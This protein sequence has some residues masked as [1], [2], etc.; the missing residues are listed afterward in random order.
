MPP[1]PPAAPVR[2]SVESEIAFYEEELKALDPGDKRRAALLHLE[3]ARLLEASG[4]VPSKIEA[5]VK[6]AAEVC[7]DLGTAHRT[8]RRFLRRRKA[9][10]EAV[11]SIDRELGGAAEPEARAA[12]H[13]ERGRLRRDALKLPT[14]AEDFVQAQA[15]QPADPSPA[16]ALRTLYGAQDA[17]SE[18][19]EALERAAAAAEPERGLM[20]RREAALL[21]DQALD[22]PDRAVVLW[23]LV[24]AAAPTDALAMAAVERLYAR[25]GRWLDLCGALVRFAEASTDTGAKYFAWLRA[26]MMAA[27]RLGE[28]DRAA[29]WLEEAARV[30]PHDPAPLDVLAEIHRRKG[31][32]EAWQ[33]ALARRARLAATPAERSGLAV[34][35]AQ[36]LAD[37]LGRRPEAIAV[38]RAAQAE[39]PSNPAVVHALLGLLGGEGQ[40][41]ER[42]KL[43]LL[44]A[45]RLGD[46]AARAAAMVRAGEACDRDPA[47]A[48]LARSAYERALQAAPDHRGAFEGLQRLYEQTAAWKP[49]AGLLEQ[50]IEATGDA[51]ERRALLR[52]LGM[53]RDERLQDRD[54]AIEAFEKLRALDPRDGAVLRELERLYAAAG[55]WAEHAAR[56]RAEAE[57]VEDPGTKA[58]LLWRA[59]VTAEE[60]AGDETGAK[61]AYQ[62]AVAAQPGHHAALDG[63]ARL[64]ERAGRWTESLEFADRALPGLAPAEQ[65]ARLLATARTSEE[66]LRNEAD[67][68]VRCRKALAL[69]PRH[70]AVLETL[71]RLYE[72]RG[73]WK[74]LVQVGLELAAGE[75]DPERGAALHVRNGDLLAERLESPVDAVAEYKAALA[76]VPTHEPA[77]LGLERVLARTGD[78]A[79]VR[80]VC[81]A[82]AEAA[83]EG[84]ARVPW[85]RKLAALTAWRLKKPREAM[86]VLDQ[87]LVLAPDDR[88]ALREL[89]LLHVREKEWRDAADTLARLAASAGEPAATAAYIK[90]E[91]AI[92]ETHLRLE[93]GERLAAALDAK[94]DDREAITLC[95]EAGAGAV[96]PNI[97]IARRLAV[98]TEPGERAMLRLR[99]AS[100][101]EEAGDSTSLFGLADLAAREAPT[102]LPAVRVARQVAEIQEDWSRTVDLLELEGTPEVTARAASRVDALCRA[103]DLAVQRL[104]RPDR[105]RATLGRAFDASPGEER[106]AA[107]LAQLLRDAGDWPALAMT[108]R[109]HASSIEAP[110]RPPILFELA[111]TLRD[112]LQSPA[113]AASVLDQ[114]LAVNPR[115]A[116]G[117]VMLAEIRAGQES[118]QQ[119]IEAFR[120]AEAA[121]GERDAE[122][123]RVRLWRVD[124]LAD[125]LGLFADAETLLRD[126]LGPDGRDVDMLRRLAAVLRRA[127]NW[128]AVEDTVARLVAVEPPEQAVEEWLELARL[129]R[130]RRDTA[131]ATE[132]FLRAA[133]LSLDAPGGIPA[134]QSFS[135]RE[136]SGDEATVVLKDVLFHLPAKLKAKAGPLHMLVGRIMA[137]QGRLMEAE[138]ELRTAVD[139][140]PDDVDAR[141]L[142]AQVSG[143]NDEVRT[144]L[145]EAVRR[146]PFRPEIYEGL[147]RLAG[148]DPRV[149]TIR[150]PA[151]QVLAAFGT[152]DPATDAYARQSLAPAGDK[153]LR[154]D[155]VVRWMVHPLEPRAAL[156]LLAAAG[157]KLA[158]LYPQPD[159]GS[160]EPVPRGTTVGQ[161][162]AAIA[163]A[164]GVAK[165]DAFFTRRSGVTATFVLDEKPQVVLAAGLGT[166]DRGLARFYLGRVFALL[167]AGQ[168]LAVLLPPGETRRLLDAVAGQHVEGLGD[169]AMVQRVGKALG[170]SVRRG[171]AGP[172]RDYATP[173]PP[174]LSGW[175]A[176]ATLTANR[177]G[178]IA[179]GDFGAARAAVHG[180]AGIPVPHSGSPAGWDAS[181]MVAPL[182]DLLQYAVSPE[183]AGVRAQLV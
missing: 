82:A 99:L 116:G 174:D 131:R 39:D 35:R 30:R 29:Q 140:L 62:A 152:I 86:G 56:L 97:L 50:R 69:A 72:R 93:T 101:M 38:L 176:A 146:D 77:F 150:A 79:V 173:A 22:Q 156:E 170:W 18:A 74:E 75:A 107:A 49:L 84:A 87:L 121:M 177:G 144:S 81:R 175:Q 63:L 53:L 48:E 70:P 51:A 90:E 126:A 159:Y 111:R 85:L 123:R 21:R 103:A 145:Q 57:L 15:L 106:V 2:P 11:Q 95:E 98:A 161:D 119:A 147:V 157:P 113:D 76:A 100:A 17:W 104:Q 132:C 128:A 92:R 125:R 60:K 108:L 47:A 181:R 52:R 26:G 178:L 136:M 141:L 168:A 41:A 169:P 109:R 165:F 14:A 137:G 73:E 83:P 115:H 180:M 166:A 6:A 58:D 54:G 13:L 40:V 134:V 16:E 32:A 23:E 110:K 153:G 34:R 164:F 42:V 179:C 65:V 160:L 27:E 133:Q 24:L 94:P 8:L 149:A 36:V 158:T 182:S 43:Q 163:A 88:A 96:A 71:A 44:A 4:A 120:L 61:T 105:A 167:A 10:E 9:W 80:E 118:W 89:F 171:L 68:V 142:L 12:L 114:L 59:G 130:G 172:C 138:G 135:L 183:Y 148:R 37:R 67:A 155:Q 162:V 19:A 66:R 64:A 45:E 139:L 31:D 1:P 122:W 112:R 129:A 91:A 7:P 127:Q 143:D 20:L 78:W 117:L 3:V 5:R 124:I 55:R 25:A 151:A 46:A 28:V 33:A 102:F 154:R